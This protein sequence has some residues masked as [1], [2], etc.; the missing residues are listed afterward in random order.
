MIKRPVNEVFK[1]NIKD[2]VLFDENLPQW[3]YVIKHQN[4]DLIF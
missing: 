3:N 1:E 2:F 4:V